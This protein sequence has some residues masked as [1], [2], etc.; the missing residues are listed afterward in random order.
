MCALLI[1]T[2]VACHTV[3]RAP[4]NATP[5]GDS[6]ATSE[7]YAAP[8]DVDITE[9]SIRR[10]YACNGYYLPLD[11]R[12][13][14]PVYM[15]G[16]CAAYSMTLGANGT[17]V[18]VGK[19]NVPVIGR[20]TGT[21]PHDDFQHLARLAVEMRFETLAA[22]YEPKSS[23]EGWACVTMDG[24]PPV[25]LSI[26]RPDKTITV[27]HNQNGPAGPEWLGVFERE[28]DGVANK[29]AWR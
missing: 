22:R 11:A 9:I 7:C 24:T 4:S 1:L 28:L 26:S 18:Y 25:T 12:G 16:P 3:P 27:W 15:T 8:P 10:D 19:E 5:A 21:I 17:A 2:P 23:L 20:R 14:G 13:K 29:I 6:F